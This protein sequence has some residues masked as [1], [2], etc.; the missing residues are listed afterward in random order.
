MMTWVRRFLDFVKRVKTI[1]QQAQNDEIGKNLN[2]YVLNQFFVKAY[3]TGEAKDGPSSF[4]GQFEERLN[5]AEEM[6]KMY[7]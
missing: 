4:Y 3:D 2:L 6:L 7:R 1:V 5:D